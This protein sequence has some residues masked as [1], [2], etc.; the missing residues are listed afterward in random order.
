MAGPI[1]FYFDFISP[2]GYFAA[3]Q[4]EAVGARHGRTIRWRTFNMR[5]VNAT[6]LGAD[7]PLFE[8]PLKGAYFRRDVPRMAAWFGLPFNPGSVAAFNPLAAA[9]AFWRLDD[10]DRALAARF[11]LEV[12]RTFHAQS[13]VPNSAAEVAA[14]A[15]R[16][17][18][19]AADIEAHVAS[20]QAKARLKSE[21]DAAVAAGVWG[22]PSFIV[23][24][25]LFWGSDRLAMLDDWLARGGW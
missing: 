11:A 23:D 25:E 19:D 10:Q 9:R 5:S 2:Y 7:K 17:G 3:E 20:P 21:T 18:A 12:L 15:G 1:D 16:C 14:I 8:L 13:I 6:I 22:T 24:G 4:I